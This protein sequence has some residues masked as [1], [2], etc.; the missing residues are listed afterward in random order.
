MPRLHQ[1][2][3][4]H[5]NYKCGLGPFDV[6]VT[7]YYKYYRGRPVQKSPDY[8]D[9][10]YTCAECGRVLSD[11]DDLIIARR[12]RS[13]GSGWPFA[14]KFWAVYVLLGAVAFVVGY[15]VT[16]KTE[17]LNVGFLAGSGVYLA[18]V[19]VLF[20]VIVRWVVD[21]VRSAKKPV[22]DFVSIETPELA[23]PPDPP[24]A[25]GDVKGN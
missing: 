23:E 19:L 16:H 18:G 24:L 10:E 13:L 25:V 14:L 5:Y 21:E 7:C 22:P 12:R 9:G 17:N 20:V 3:A 11:D 2:Q 15:L 8:N 1:N 4:S 6:C